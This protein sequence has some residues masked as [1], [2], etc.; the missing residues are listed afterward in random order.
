MRDPLWEKKERKRKERREGEIFKM[1]KYKFGE[2]KSVS[3]KKVT[4]CS[5]LFKVI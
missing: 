1:L 4:N 3:S 2:A 5:K